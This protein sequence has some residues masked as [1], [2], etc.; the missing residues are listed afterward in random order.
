MSKF[1][2]AYDNAK[3]IAVPQGFLESSRDKKCFCISTS[4]N[5]CHLVRRYP[6]TKQHFRLVQILSIG[7]QQIICSSKNRYGFFTHYQ[8]TK[9]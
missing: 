4:L 6:F 2:H 1:L 7:M 5:L 3:A 8:M 9:F